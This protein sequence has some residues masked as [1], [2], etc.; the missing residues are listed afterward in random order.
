MTA[1]AHD[2]PRG[3]FHHVTGGIPTAFLEAVALSIP[4]ASA[5]GAAVPVA[6]L[7]SPDGLL[8][9]LL[10]HAAMASPRGVM[11]ELM[12][13]RDAITGWVAI[14]VSGDPAFLRDALLSLPET[15]PGVRDV[16]PAIG[17]ALRWLADRRL[18]SP[19]RD[20]TD[21]RMALR[22]SSLLAA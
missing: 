17:S 15:E 9:V 11:P 8:P 5:D 22:A 13:D 3:E 12:E 14:G 6:M 20:A 7:G 18:P 2:A 10:L 16:G 1:Q 19:L 4:A 21:L